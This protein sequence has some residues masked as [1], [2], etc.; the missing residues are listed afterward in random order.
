[1]CCLSTTFVIRFQRFVGGEPRW[2]NQTTPTAGQ[3]KSGHKIASPIA[4]DGGAAAPARREQRRPERGERRVQ[5][6]DRRRGSDVSESERAREG[7][8]HE[9]QPTER[10]GAPPG[11]SAPEVARE[12]H[13]IVVDLG[14]GDR[15]RLGVACLDPEVAS[16]DRGAIGA[17]HR[18]GRATLSR[19]WEV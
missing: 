5:S 16:G 8:E 17:E 18:G 11:E 10:A 4:I 3:V 19:A 15:R 1:M 2:A 14:G 6:A 7:G 9:D 12:D 13:R